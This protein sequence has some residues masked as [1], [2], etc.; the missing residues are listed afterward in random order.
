MSIKKY[1]QHYAA[2]E[3]MVS[4]EKRIV[5]TIRELSRKYMDTSDRIKE[6]EAAG[7]IRA[8]NKLFYRNTKQTGALINELRKSQARLIGGA[9]PKMINEELDNLH[10]AEKGIKRA[11]R[12]SLEKDLDMVRKHM[13]R[14]SKKERRAY[15]LRELADPS[16]PHFPMDLSVYDPSPEDYNKLHWYI[17]NNPKK[18]IAAGAA[19]TAGT[20]YGGYRYYKH[21]K[22]KK[23]QD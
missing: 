22:N 23:E 11:A 16:V 6:L 13:G 7:D 8:A 14:M 5:D 9:S 3:S 21:R 17:K 20:A 4:T 12:A 2:K 19:L 1:L 18:S 15:K 10:I